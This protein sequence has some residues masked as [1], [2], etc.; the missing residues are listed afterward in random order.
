MKDLPTDNCDARRHLAHFDRI[1]KNAKLG[2]NKFKAK[3]IRT[4]CQLLKKKNT[5]PS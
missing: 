1:F 5:D 3:Q 4:S 2:N